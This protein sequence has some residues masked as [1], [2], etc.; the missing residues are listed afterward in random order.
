MQNGGQDSQFNVA[1]Y[2]AQ[3]YTKGSKLQE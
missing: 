2:R 1:A 3:A